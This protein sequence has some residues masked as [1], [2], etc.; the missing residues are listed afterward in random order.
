M[1]SFGVIDAF[2]CG[3]SHLPGAGFSVDPGSGEV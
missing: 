3:K 1:R 2:A